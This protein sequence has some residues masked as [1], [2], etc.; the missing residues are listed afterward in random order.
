MPT[1]PTSSSGRPP[2]CRATAGEWIA[3]WRDLVDFEVLPVMTSADPAATIAPRSA[4]APVPTAPVAAMPATVAAPVQPVQGQDADRS[5]KGGISVDGWKGR[6]DRRPASQGKTV[7]DSKVVAAPGGFRLS[8]GPAGNFWNDANTASGNYTVKATF[9]GIFS[10]L[11]LK[12]TSESLY[13]FVSFAS[14]VVLSL[15]TYANA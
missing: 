15:P 1:S 4:V 3:R 11:L 6:V 5:V 14:L 12:V 8:V 2:R 7:N 10:D 9:T 13:A